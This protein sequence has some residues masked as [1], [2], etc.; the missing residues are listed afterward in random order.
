MS[1][2]L[3]ISVYS[4]YRKQVKIAHCCISEHVWLSPTS[5]LQSLDSRA[6]KALHWGHFLHYSWKSLLAWAS[7][8][9]VIPSLV[10]NLFKQWRRSPVRGA[11]AQ[12]HTTREAAVLAPAYKTPGKAKRDRRETE[13]KPDSSPKEKQTNKKLQQQ[14]PHTVANIGVLRL[15]GFYL[16]L[17]K[18]PT[19]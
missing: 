17:C 3:R 1:S 11:Q 5:S 4:T 6:V 7:L 8:Q 13:N 12:P 15:K 16:S 18:D 19:L 9:L 10:Q 14:R 2:L